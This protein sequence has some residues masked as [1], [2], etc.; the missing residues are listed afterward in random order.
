MNSEETVF[1]KSY[2]NYLEQLDTLDFESVAPKLGGKSD[3]KS[4]TIP[5]FGS[6][7]RM[8]S[9][10]IA[11]PSGET[12]SYD[13]CVILCNYLLRCPGDSPSDKEWA[14][15]RDLRDSGPLVTYFTNEVEG[16]ATLFFSGKVQGLKQAGTLLGGNRPELDAEYDVAMQFNALPMIPVLMLFNDTD[17]EFPASCSVLFERQVEAYL[18]AE[19]IAMLGRQLFVHLKKSSER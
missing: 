14:S 12:P 19:C 13:I 10:G 15:F 11:G 2:A 8:S 16:A 9:E 4:V 6:G 7:Y 5:F 1:Q 18:D 3:G 17:N